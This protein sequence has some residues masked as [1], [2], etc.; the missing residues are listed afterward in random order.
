M[1]GVDGEPVQVEHD[2]GPPSVYE[3]KR[4]CKTS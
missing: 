1:F 2:S 3:K 4:S